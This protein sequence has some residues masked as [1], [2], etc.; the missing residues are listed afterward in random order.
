MG[1]PEAALLFVPTY[2]QA[3]GFAFYNLCVHTPRRTTGPPQGR[4]RH[5]VLTRRAATLRAHRRLF[6]AIVAGC[7]A[8]VLGLTN[9]LGLLSYLVAM[10]LVR[11]R[12]HNRGDVFRGLLQLAVL[13]SPVRLVSS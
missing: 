1:E 6:T 2:I 7:V 5:R 4:D 3:N 11:A 12:L 9:G 10:L 13:R 8:G